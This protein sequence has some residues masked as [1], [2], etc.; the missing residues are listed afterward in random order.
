MTYLELLQLLQD[1]VVRHVVEEPVGGRED[2]VTQLDVEGRAVC[3]IRAAGAD[4][5]KVK[6]GNN[7]C[8]R[9][10]DLSDSG[11]YFFFVSR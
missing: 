9:F 5:V 1:H 10:G 7:A 2:D 4:A 6:A 8:D 3:C 11:C